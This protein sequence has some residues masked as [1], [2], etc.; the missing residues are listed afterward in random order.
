MM[1]V[2]SGPQIMCTF[3]FTL[4]SPFRRAPVFAVVVV[5][6]L[7][8]IISVMSSHCTSAY[9]FSSCTLLCASSGQIH[10]YT[11]FHSLYNKYNIS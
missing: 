2:Y 6:V 9:Q 11:L 4:E 8:Y 5:S 1:I 7:D 3:M 10:E